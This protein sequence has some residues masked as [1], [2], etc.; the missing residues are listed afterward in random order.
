MLL[1]DGRMIWGETCGFLLRLSLEVC[2]LEGCCVEAARAAPSE[3]DAETIL[4]TTDSNLLLSTLS[5]CRGVA[6]VGVAFPAPTPVTTEDLCVLYT[7]G[8]DD[9]AGAWMTSGVVPLPIGRGA[10][11]GAREGAAA[12]DGTT[13][14][15]ELLLLLDKTCLLTTRNPCDCCN[16][17]CWCG[18]GSGCDDSDCCGCGGDA[19]L[20]CCCT[21]CTLPPFWLRCAC[22]SS[23]MSSEPVDSR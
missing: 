22:S 21:S 8:D 2:L 19:L 10:R 9:F 6:V 20:L 7:C 14:P 23:V 5:L 1:L 15:L 18:G 11:E 13:L 3:D 16:P 4:L 17:C 12:T